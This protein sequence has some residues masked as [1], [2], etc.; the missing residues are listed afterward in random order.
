[1]NVKD[2]DLLDPSNPDSRRHVHD[3][4][5]TDKLDKE[6]QMNYAS[7]AIKVA[8]LLRQRE[9]DVDDLILAWSYLDEN[10]EVPQDIRE[11]N[12]ITSF[13]QALRHHQT[14]YNYEGLRFLATHFGGKEGERLVKIYEGQLK[15]N[16]KQRVKAEKV[17]KKA[18]RLV[19][20]LNWKNYSDQDIVDFR[21]ML[22]RVLKRG[23]HEFVL[24]SVREGCI[25]LVYII[26]SD[27]CESIRSLSDLQVY[28]VMDVTI[29]GYVGLRKF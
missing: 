5:Q 17:P 2:D 10:T 16:V 27:L 14:W 3:R 18:S 8:E 11:A 20:K 19:V 7:F 25:E 29:N 6:A 15:Q 13:V 4:C 9:I 1:M 21:N 28:G 23:P 12:S 26:P 22:A 24:K